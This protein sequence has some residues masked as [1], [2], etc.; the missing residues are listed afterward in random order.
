[1][2]DFEALL[3]RVQLRAPARREGR[4][5]LRPARWSLSSAC[6]VRHR[7]VT[8]GGG[9]RMLA[10]GVVVGHREWFEAGGEGSSA[11]QGVAILWGSVSTGSFHHTRRRVPYLRYFL[12]HP[13]EVTRIYLPWGRQIQ[14]RDTCSGHR[15]PNPCLPNASTLCDKRMG[16][17]AIGFY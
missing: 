11:P 2:H 5:R 14:R 13:I 10:V 16:T 17:P 3:A 7:V 4:R 1:M 15:A 8:G 12:C 6:N 9:T